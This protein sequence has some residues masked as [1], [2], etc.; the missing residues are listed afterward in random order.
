V[1]LPGELASRFAVI[2]E[3]ASPGAEADVVL[4]EEVSSSRQV[5]VKLYRRGVDPDE[6]AI[7]RLAEASRPG[8]PGWAHVVEVIDWG[9][10]EGC[11]FEVL[12][13]C[14]RGS[15]RALMVDGPRPDLAEVVRELA[16][17][18]SFAHGLG[19]VHRDLKPENVLVRSVSPLDLV[20]GDFGLARAI[21]AS[22]RW[23]RAW[24]TPAYSPP[25]LAG[26]EVSPAW[27]WWS[28]GMIVAE[29]AGGRH[30]FEL[31]DGTM[32]SD[33][34]IQSSL[35]Q[36]PVD[37]SAVTDPR[38]GLL[39]RGLLT[40]DRASRWGGDRVKE[41]LAGQSPAVAADNFTVA[42]GRVRSVLFAGVEYASPVELATAFQQHWNDAFR[43]LFQERDRD[44][45]DELERLLRY[46][47][48][49]EAVLV[50]GS[51]SASPTELPRRFADLLAEMDP[52]LDPVYKGIP[53]TPIGLEESALTVVRGGGDDP[54]AAVLDE[55]RRQNIL[56]R[57]R[58][59]PGMAHGPA[60]QQAWMA[61]NGD[62]ETA[63]R[64]IGSANFSPDTNDWAIANAWLLL[65]VLDPDHH[66]SQL[67]KLVDDLDPTYADQQPWWHSLRTAAKKTPP[68]LALTMLSQ[69]AAT[70]QTH[71]QIEQARQVEE[72]RAARAR[73]DKEIA[74]ERQRAEQQ[75]QQAELRGARDASRARIGWVG[76]AAVAG[77]GPF[78][79]MALAIHAGQGYADILGIPCFACLVFGCP[80]ALSKAFKRRRT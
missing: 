41:W 72:E 39:C 54:A 29:M 49:D 77:A 46:H 58:R 78:G 23:T 33:Q 14:E 32:M 17:A 7:D 2:R 51:Q 27:D 57:W 70:E 15:L 76:L 37:L 10:T 34:Q 63:A 3:L 18:L 66:T 47:E 36:R 26:G 60:T 38:M 48:L 25:E 55:V 65:C 35:A 61:G 1:N 69:P 42:G 53:L 43:R 28:L 13:F 22:V 59:L 21:D 19:L 44:L 24:G 11:W 71:R 45:V 80:V 67:A 30:P 75:R 68:S 6:T 52:E 12:E 5:I 20:L 50:L 31:V 56:T 9:L 16:A 40:R 79:V 74:A 62:F 64:A 8:T 4:A 73:R